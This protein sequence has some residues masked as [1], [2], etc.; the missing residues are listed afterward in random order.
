MSI[1]YSDFPSLAWVKCDPQSLE[2][3]QKFGGYRQQEEEFFSR[4]EALPMIFDSIAIRNSR[5]KELPNCTHQNFLVS[6]SLIHVIKAEKWWWNFWRSNYLRNEKAAASGVAV[7]DAKN[8]IHYVYIIEEAAETLDMTGF[9]G[10]HIAVEL[11]YGDRCVGFEEGIIKA[12]GTIDITPWGHYKL[13]AKKELGK[14]ISFVVGLLGYAKSNGLSKLVPA[15][16]NQTNE[17]IYF[18]D[19]YLR[20]GTIEGKEFY[21]ANPNPGISLHAILPTVSLF[22]VAIYTDGLSEQ[23][24]KDWTNNQNI[25]AQFDFIEGIPFFVVD[26]GSWSIN[27]PINIRSIARL[28]D[29]EGWLMQTGNAAHLFLVDATTNIIIAEKVICIK[30]KDLVECKKV[31]KQQLSMYPTWQKVLE[32]IEQLLEQKNNDL[33]IASILN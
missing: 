14:Y 24:M 6:D 15:D 18:A 12:N 20:A 30:N 16:L 25:T 31:L 10:N 9:E 7:V 22:D 32:K 27:S 21:Q 11:F 8:K 13:G 17:L 28:E 33:L 29:I 3:A 4:S 19:H 2:Q 1:N 26:F 5:H 23:E